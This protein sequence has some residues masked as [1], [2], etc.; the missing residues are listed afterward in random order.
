MRLRRLATRIPRM[1]ESFA[2]ERDARAV[3]SPGVRSA[4]ATHLFIVP[5]DTL[6]ISSLVN[7]TYILH[8]HAMPIF[9]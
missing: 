7:Q 9:S 8:V 6:Y 3:A 1:C 2:H 4:A 5:E